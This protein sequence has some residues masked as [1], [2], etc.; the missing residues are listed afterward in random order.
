MRLGA[1]PLVFAASRDPSRRWSTV[2]GLEAQ[3]LV[4]A[5]PLA[6][7]FLNEVSPMHLITR[8]AC[9]AILACVANLALADDIR[10][11]RVLEMIID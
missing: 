7:S 1:E 10:T 8:A 2:A 9:A 5:R 3:H 6:L 4:L 11:E